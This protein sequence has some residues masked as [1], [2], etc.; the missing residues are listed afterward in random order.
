MKVAVRLRHAIVKDTS[1]WS[2]V[3]VKSPESH[4]ARSH[5]AQNQSH[6]ARNSWSCRLKLMV[7]SPEISKK[8]ELV[9]NLVR[10]K[11]EPEVVSF[12]ITEI[13]IL[14]VYVEAFCF[15]RTTTY[16]KTPPSCLQTCS[17]KNHGCKASLRH[18]GKFRHA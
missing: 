5:V 2:W 8:C 3:K 6:V 17:D 10:V 13:V 12:D 9:K 11:C 18:C 4:V 16:W 14:K 7:M 15:E 1:P